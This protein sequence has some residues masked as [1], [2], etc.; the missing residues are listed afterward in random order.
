MPK[1]YKTIHAGECDTYSALGDVEA[2]STNTTHVC[3][4]IIV[5]LSIEALYAQL[6]VYTYMVNT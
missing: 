5:Y 6:V 3:G 1:C 2:G 4:D